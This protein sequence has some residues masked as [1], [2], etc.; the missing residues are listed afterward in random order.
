ML[1]FKNGDTV[2][3]E[4]IKHDMIKEGNLKLDIHLGRFG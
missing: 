1:A 4:P 2:L 3:G